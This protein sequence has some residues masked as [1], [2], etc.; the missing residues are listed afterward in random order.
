M[1]H[2]RHCRLYYPA[3]GTE[4]AHRSFPPRL[5]PCLAGMAAGV[6]RGGGHLSG[7]LFSRIRRGLIPRA[8]GDGTPLRILS[9]AEYGMLSGR[10]GTGVPRHR[11]SWLI[12]AVDPQAAGDRLCRMLRGYWSMI[13]SRHS[14]RPGLLALNHLELLMLIPARAVFRRG[15]AAPFPGSRRLS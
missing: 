14:E 9:I 7:F 13:D 5:I 6:A 1:P 3:S 12:P 11:Q 10:R 15:G 2:R 4:S 8:S